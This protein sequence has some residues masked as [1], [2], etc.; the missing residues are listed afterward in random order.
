MKEGIHMLQPGLK[1]TASGTVE[2]R[3]TAKEM[4]SGSL[5]VLATPAMAALMEQAA[6]NAVAAELEEGVTSVGTRLDLRHDAATPVGMEVT[7]EATLTAV[8]GRRLTFTIEAADEK[9]PIGS[10]AHERVLVTAERFLERA[11]QKL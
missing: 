1:G 4:G 6:C 5:L 2:R 3:D 11:Y 8:D 10:C 7:A 9:G